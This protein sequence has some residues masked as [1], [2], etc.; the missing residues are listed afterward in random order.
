MEGGMSP[1][2][3]FLAR[4]IGPYC[5]LVALSMLAHKQATVETITALIHNAP[6]MMLTSIFALVAGLAIVLGHNVWSGSALPVVITVVG[7]MALIKGLLFLFLTPE[8][9]V[10]FFEVARYGQLFYVYASFS[11]ILGVYLAYGGFKSTLR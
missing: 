5:I 2:T 4:L 1:R 3:T 9:T 6:A 10:E 7:W 11:L 8:A